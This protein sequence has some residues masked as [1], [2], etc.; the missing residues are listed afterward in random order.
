MSSSYVLHAHDLPLNL[1]AL[2]ETGVDEMSWDDTEN[3]RMGGEFKWPSLEEVHK[4]RMT[5]RDIVST[6]IASAPFNLPINM[7]NPLWVGFAGLGVS[8]RPNHSG[9]LL[10]CIGHSSLDR[11]RTDSHRDVVGADS[12]TPNKIH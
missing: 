5:V 7:E 1:Q 10:T 12:A 4:Y 3:F 9:R 11:A 6:V 8:L 2:F